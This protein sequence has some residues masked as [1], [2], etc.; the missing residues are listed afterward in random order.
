MKKRVGVARA[1]VGQP[2]Y[3]FYD[4]PT[5]GLDPVTSQQIDNMIY[6]LSRKLKVTSI[7]ITHDIFSVNNVADKVA[8]LHNGKLWFYGNVEEMNN[9]YDEIVKDFVSRYTN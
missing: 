8:M 3:I 7:V 5:T 1:L 4:E 6:E 9:S 2:E